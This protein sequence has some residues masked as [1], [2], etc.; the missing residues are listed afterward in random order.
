MNKLTISDVS[1]LPISNNI[2]FLFFS[3]LI[4]SVCRYIKSQYIIFFVSKYSPF[5]IDNKHI[6]LSHY[7]IPNQ[8]K[9]NQTNI[10]LLH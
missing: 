1:L 5:P 10:K 6:L 9:P 3:I 2:E 8:T 7:T 4:I